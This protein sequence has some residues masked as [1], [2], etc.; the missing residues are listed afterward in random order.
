MSLYT[1]LFFNTA[2]SIR[3]RLNYIHNDRNWCQ[4]KKTQKM[5]TYLVAFVISDF[6]PDPK[7]DALLKLWARPNAQSQAVYG[8]EIGTKILKKFGEIFGQEYY[9]ETTK[10]MDMVAVPDFSAGKKF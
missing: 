10:K 3:K 7:N 1:N 9:D 8:Q 5:S 4:F 6:R 2:K